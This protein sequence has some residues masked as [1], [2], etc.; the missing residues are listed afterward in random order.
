MLLRASI[1]C[2][3]LLAAPALAQGGYRTEEF[4]PIGIELPVPRDYKA[5]PVEPTER[6]IVLR[7]V[8][9]ETAERRA[10]DEGV[11]TSSV[12]APELMLLWI[13]YVPDPVVTGAGQQG[14]EG[15]DSSD[16]ESA[17]G[18]QAEVELPV[19]T[20]ERYLDRYW[21]RGKD[22]MYRLGAVEELKPRDGNTVS[23]YVL[24]P[25]G[26]HPPAWATV[27]RT[28]RRSLVLFGRCDDVDWRDQT[29]IWQHMARRADL[30]EP[31]ALDLSK[32]ERF[33]ERRPEY[34]DPEYR[35]GVRSKLVRGWDALDTPHYI[36][37]YSTKDEVLMRDLERKLE[38]IRAE[39]ERTFPPEAPVTAVSTVRICRDR[40]EYLQYGGSPWSGGYWNWVAGELVFYDYK[41]DQ[42]RK[43]EGME[44]SRIVLLHEA[45]HQYI[46]YSVGELPPHS[47]F[48]EGTG[49]FF[50]G[51][52]IKGSKVMKVEPNP[53]R[54]GLIQKLVG[55]QPDKV[56]PFA[57][58]MAFEQPEFYRPD[59]RSACYAQ[60]WSMI[61]FLRTSREV[62]DHDQWSQILPVYF[63]AL[64]A[65]Y[66][67]RTAALGDDADWAARAAA[68]VES[69]KAALAAA[70]E[71]VDLD[72]LQEAWREFV[73]DLR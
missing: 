40:D 55:E 62:R 61:Y 53:W 52:L 39:F 9:E 34:V 7:W 29:K 42:E 72:A 36:F 56:L 3:P 31:E 8:D 24:H 1:L 51:A 70:T 35:L 19:S 50:S 64:K 17:E 43:G 16:G 67:E 15:P 49:D 38:A 59:R 26:D 33:Y 66:R 4:E 60:A 12:F 46:F 23:E 32:W 6:W 71:G 5:V 27:F 30:F 73:L 2:L 18:E 47:W 65:D 45:F 14:P 13:D 25:V 48:N 21:R 58:I 44:N 10:E 69:R 28:G 11:Q 54:I 22:P 37:V 57:E 20:F 68:G 63:D 41:A